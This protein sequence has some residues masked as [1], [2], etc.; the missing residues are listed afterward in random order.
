MQA[1]VYGM[2]TFEHYLRGRVF[3]LYSDH[4]LL[5]KLSTVHTKTLN[6]LQLKMQEMYPEMRYVPGKEN[7]VA[8]F[9]S[10]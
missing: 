2:E 9:L 8:D 5:V 3:C 4:K 6:R 10:R 1:A 7:T